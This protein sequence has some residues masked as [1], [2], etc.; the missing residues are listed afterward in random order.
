MSAESFELQQ[1]CAQQTAECIQRFAIK[2]AHHFVMS[3][4]TNTL[5]S[6]TETNQL[7]RQRPAIQPPSP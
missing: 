3:L 1:L 7:S 4:L 5:K 2:K 6:K